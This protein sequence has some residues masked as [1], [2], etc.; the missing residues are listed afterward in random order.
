MSQ[1]DFF[2]KLGAPLVNVR[3]S[4]GAIRE[5]D[6]TVFLRVWDHEVQ[7]REGREFVRVC[8]AASQVDSTG[9]R[10][11]TDHTTRSASSC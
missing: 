8:R 7:T 10:A 5:R 4:W 6:T 1:K 9:L 2:A 11:R 3:W